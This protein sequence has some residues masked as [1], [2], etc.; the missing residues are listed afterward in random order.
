M[1]S[2]QAVIGPLC[3][4]TAP[5]AKLSSPE[6]LSGLSFPGKR[7]LAAVLDGSQGSTY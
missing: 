4:P 6:A 3:G 7:E 2:Q 1:N 5:L